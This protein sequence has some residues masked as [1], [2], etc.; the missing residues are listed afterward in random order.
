MNAIPTFTIERPMHEEYETVV[1][2]NP[3]NVLDI[4]AP[5]WDPSQHNMD[6]QATNATIS[7]IMNTQLTTGG[8]K[9]TLNGLLASHKNPENKFFDLEENPP[10]V[11]FDAMEMDPGDMF[12]DPFDDEETAE[13]MEPSEEQHSSGE[14]EQAMDS[15]EE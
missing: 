13:E 4:A 8:H 11:F 9:L 1:K 12:S 7:Q 2:E 3:E 6:S 5:N 15:G 10:D 14:T